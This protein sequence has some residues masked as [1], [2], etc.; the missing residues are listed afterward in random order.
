MEAAR[1]LS[2]GGGLNIGTGCKTFGSILLL[3]PGPFLDT[4]T[5]G[6][7]IVPIIAPRLP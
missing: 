1:G 2:I 7:A 5:F 4:K 6:F 3:A